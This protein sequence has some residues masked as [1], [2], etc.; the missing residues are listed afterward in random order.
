MAR[1]A[2]ALAPRLSPIA[3]GAFEVRSVK[4]FADTFDGKADDYMVAT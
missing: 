1:G 4:R 2:L 3:A